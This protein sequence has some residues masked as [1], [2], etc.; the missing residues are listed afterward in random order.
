MRLGFACVWIASMPESCFV[1]F[2]L[3]RACDRI[4]S[5]ILRIWL[6]SLA[7]ISMI[8]V[9]RGDQTEDKNRQ[10][11]EFSSAMCG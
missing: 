9:L 8:T 6:C 4:A 1:G 2:W 11:S 5:P 3:L 10:D 7:F